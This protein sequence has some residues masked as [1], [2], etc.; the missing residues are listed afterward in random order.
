[1]VARFFELAGTAGRGIFIQNY[2]RREFFGGQQQSVGD[3]VDHSSSHSTADL[4][5]A[6]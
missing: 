5:R 2:K 1:M 6:V 3:V 4:P